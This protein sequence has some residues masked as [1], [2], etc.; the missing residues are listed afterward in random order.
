MKLRITNYE[1][2]ITKLFNLIGLSGV[3]QAAFLLLAAHCSLLTASA[4]LNSGAQQNVNGRAGTFAIRNARIVTVSGATIENGTVVISNGK[5]TAVGANVAIPGGAETIEGRG[6]SVFPGLIDAGTNLGL[7]E[8]G[9]G[10]NSTV[11]VAEIGDMNANAKAILAVNPH[12]SHVNVTRVNGI[13]SVLSMPSGGVMAGQATVI[14]LVGSTQNDMALVPTYGLVINFPR[15][16]TG[17]GFGGG[18]GGQPV[19]FGEAVRRGD[20]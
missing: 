7:A 18:F 12:S 6:L 16:T 17:G 19:D 9:Q 10:A 5:I 14:N 2:R 13:T 8:V 3:R 4:Q 1:L 15:V 11:D 20:Q